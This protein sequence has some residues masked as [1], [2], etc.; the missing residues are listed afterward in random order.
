MNLE[1]FKTKEHYKRYLLEKSIL[2]ATVESKWWDDNNI[3]F[4]SYLEETQEQVEKELEEY[5]RTIQ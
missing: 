5:D 1:D 3:S 4:I 2:L